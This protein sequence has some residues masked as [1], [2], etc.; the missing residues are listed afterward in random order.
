MNCIYLNIAGFIIKVIF[1]NTDWD[2]IS[3]KMID[4]IKEN[5]NG[6]IVKKEDKKIDFTIRFIEKRNFIGK[7]D[8]SGHQ[9]VVIFEKKSKK[10]MD[11]YYQ[12]GFIQFQFILREVINDLLSENDGYILHASAVS[13][14]NQAY[15]FLGKPSAGKSTIMKLASKI[16]KPLADDSVYIRKINNDFYL[17]QTPMIEKEMIRNKSNKR[18]FI[19]KIFFL[20]KGKN[21][22]L[23]AIDIKKKIIQL[24][25]RQIQTNKNLLKKQFPKL[26]DFVNKKNTFY[27]LT[28]SKKSKINL[29]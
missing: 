3:N 27:I 6:F 26:V 12:I 19:K 28:F 4:D 20:K 7:T 21:F 10:L 15:I 22:L 25:F 23:E 8:K 5:L 1:G 24:F 14:N 9:F 13:L 16:Y 18:F 17:F 2:F 29:D 11:T